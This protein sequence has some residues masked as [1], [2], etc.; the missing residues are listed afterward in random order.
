LP[1]ALD[2]QVWCDGV[3]IFGNI[4]DF[5]HDLPPWNVRLRVEVSARTRGRGF[6]IPL[7]FL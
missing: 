6:T 2:D 5:I 1:G 3:V 7:F 4:R